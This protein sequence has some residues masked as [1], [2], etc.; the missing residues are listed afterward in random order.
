MRIAPGLLVPLLL[1][2][3]ATTELVPCADPRPQVCTMIYNPTCAERLDGTRADYSSPCN[4]CADE[5]VTG[6]VPG[7]CPE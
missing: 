7:A 5:S 1:S 2:A 4:A 3:C 6:Y